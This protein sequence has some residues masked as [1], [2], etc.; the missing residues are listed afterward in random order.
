MTETLGVTTAGEYKTAYLGLILGIGYHWRG[1]GE[2]YE[3]LFFE[4]LFMGHVVLII[5]T[6]T[7]AQGVDLSAARLLHQ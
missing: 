1:I 4:K 2:S 3:K 6:A 5:S 7:L